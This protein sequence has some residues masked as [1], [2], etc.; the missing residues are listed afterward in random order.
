MWKR[1]TI[2]KKKEVPMFDLDWFEDPVY[3]IM[4]IGPLAEDLA[5]EER[6]RRRP[7]DDID[8]DDEE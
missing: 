2:M 8:Q 1:K 5:D 3:P 7:E 4:I 6:E